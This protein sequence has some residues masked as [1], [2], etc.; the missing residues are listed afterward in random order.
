M[1]RPEARRVRSHP[2]PV[3]RAGS[4]VFQT[5]RSALMTQSRRR[6][7]PQKNR[8]PSRCPFKPHCGYK[9]VCLL[10]LLYLYNHFAFDS[11]PL[12]FHQF[13]W[14]LSVLLRFSSQIKKQKLTKSINIVKNTSK[15]HHKKYKI[16]KQT[17]RNAKLKKKEQNRWKL[18]NFKITKENNK[19]N[20][21]KNGKTSRKNNKKRKK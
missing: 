2:F 9:Y 19:I 6:D 21:M 14:L 18:Q 1:N 13:Y 16:N 10:F 15:M 5:R 4:R 7:T 3:G 17:K 20:K 12:F 8:I 11:P